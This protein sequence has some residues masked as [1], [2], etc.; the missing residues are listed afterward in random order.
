VPGGVDRED[1]VSGVLDDAVLLS[2]PTASD[3]ALTAVLSAGRIAVSGTLQPDQVVTVSYT[4]RVKSDADRVADGGDDELGNFLVDPGTAPPSTCGPDAEDCTYH[5]IPRIVDSKSVTPTDGQTVVAGTELTYTL[6]FGNEGEAAGG[7]EREDVVS[8][9]LD[10]AVLL[11]GP[12]ASDPALTAVL[13]AGRI[14]VSGTLQPDQVVTVSYTVRVKSDADRVADGGDDELGNFIVDPGVQPPTECGPDDAHCTRNPVSQIEDTKTVNPASGTTVVAG[15]ELTYTLTFTNSGRGVGPVDR[16]DDLTNVLD[17]ATLLDGPTVSDPALTA[18]GPNDGRIAITGGLASGDTV[19]VTY[20]VRVRPFADQGDHSLGNWLLDPGEKRPVGCETTDDST[21]N[22]VSEI[23]ATKEVQRRDGSEVNAGDELTYTLRFI[24]RGDGEGRVSYE[25]RLSDVLD[26][27]SLVDGPAASDPALRV[28]T[29][30]QGRIRVT[31]TLAGGQ[32][33]TVTYTVRVKP[34]G[35]RGNDQLNNWLVAS[36]AA[37]PE[38]CAPSSPLCTVNGISETA[39]SPSGDGALPDTGG[40]AL[41]ALLAGL[42][43]LGG[44]TLLLLKRRRDPGRP[45]V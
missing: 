35:E 6:R 29:V 4:V 32:R 43:L 10:D 20:T 34:D 22:P 37:T 5:P 7:V 45:S 23:E 41:L 31:G 25:D 3:P 38:D 27:A 12:T 19:T 39:G 18:T 11:S 44:G 33:A 36:A 2:G 40:P 1:V 42:G 26:D 15:Q 30:R 14:A 21:C 17:D 24:N 8:G 9:V 13:S 28:S 16:V